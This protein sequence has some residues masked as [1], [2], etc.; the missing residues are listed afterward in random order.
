MPRY[1]VSC[2]IHEAVLPQLKDG[3]P[4]DPLVVMRCFGE[5]RMTSVKTGKTS[6]ACWDESFHWPNFELSSSAWSVGVLEF[7]LQS[8]NAFWR[9]TTLGMCALQLRL[10]CATSDGCY[11]GRLPLTSPNS[12]R[13]I[14]QLFITVNVCDSLRVSGGSALTSISQPSEDT[15]D[16]GSGQL[17][18]LLSPLVYKSSTLEPFSEEY[19]YYHLYINV[20]SL[21]HVE[22]GMFGSSPSITV[23]YG[24]C[25]LQSTKPVRLRSEGSPSSDGQSGLIS[26]MISGIISGNNRPVGSSRSNYEFNQCFLVPIRTSVGKPVLEDNIVVRIWMGVELSTTGSVA[27]LSPRLLAEGVFSLAKLRARRQAPRWFN[28]YRGCVTPSGALDMLSHDAMLPKGNE[29]DHYIGRLLMS[30]SVKRLSKPSDVLVA[31]VQSSYALESRVSNPTRLFVD[32]YCVESSGTFGFEDP[33]EVMIEISC[34]PYETS[35]RWFTPHY[36]TGNP[37]NFDST[38]FEFSRRFRSGWKL[39]LNSVTGRLS[40]IELSSSY[41][42]EEQ[43]LVFV[44]VRCRGMVSG[45]YQERLIASSSYPFAHIAEYTG[46]SQVMPLWLPVSC[47]GS[48]STLNSTENSN[49]DPLE[50]LDTV[51]SMDPGNMLQSVVSMDPTGILGSAAS[52]LA[53]LSTDKDMSLDVSGTKPRDRVA[54]RGS[55]IST[56]DGVTT[57]TLGDMC[58]PGATVN[59]LLT[60]HTHSFHLDLCRSVGNDIRSTSRPQMV[61]MLKQDYELRCYVYCARLNTAPHSGVAVMLSCDGAVARTQVQ[62]NLTCFPVFGECC[63]ISVSAPT[64]TSN[65]MV[66]PLPITVS[67]CYLG[68]GRRLLRMESAVTMYNRLVKSSKI[69]TSS[70]PSPCWLTLS[71]GSQL[72]IY[73]ELVL[74]SEAARV[75]KYQVSPTVTRCNIALGLIGLRQLLVPRNY[76]LDSVFFKISS[77]SYG[78]NL[79][80]E[81]VYSRHHPVGS[82]RW[83]RGGLLNIDMFTVQQCSFHIPL[84][85]LFDPHVEIYFYAMSKGELGPLLGYRSFR[86]YQGYSE[87]TSRSH[88]LRYSLNPRKLVHLLQSLSLK[89]SD[90]LSLDGIEDDYTVPR[91][92]EGAA[93]KLNDYERSRHYKRLMRSMDFERVGMYV[94]PRFVV[95]CDGRASEASADSMDLSCSEALD[96]VLHDIPFMIDDIS[97]RSAVGFRCHGNPVSANSVMK[98]F[99]TIRHS[100]DNLVHRS[101]PESFERVATKSSR[102]QKALR[103]GLSKNLHKLRFCVVSANNLVAEVNSSLFLAVEIGG[104]ESREALSTDGGSIMRL[105]QRTWEQDLFLPED[106]LIN[107]RVVSSFERLDGTLV[108]RVRASAQLDLENRWHSS[109]W[110]RMVR[111]DCVPIERVV[112]RDSDNNVHGSLDVIVQLGPVELFSTLRPFNFTKPVQSLIEL[113]VVVWSTRGVHLPTT[114]VDAR[115]K[116]QL[117]LYVVSTLDCQGY[118]GDAPL[119]QRTDTHYNCDSGS[120]QFN[121]RMVYPEIHSPVGACQLQLSVYDFW[122]VGPPVFIGEATLE[123]RQYVAVVSSTATRVDLSADLPLVNSASA[124]PVGTLKVNVQVLTQSESTCSPVGLGRNS[125]NCKPFLPTPRAGRQWQDWFAHTSLGLDFGFLT[126]Y[127]SSIQ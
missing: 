93:S 100:R 95:A 108:D 23:E 28:F 118:R 45:V 26:D 84:D 11:V 40:P 85:P 71:G 103:K 86:C 80:S 17:P 127:V 63:T 97:P 9:N 107:L 105:I 96:G 56:T 112:L 24:G 123:L 44:R 119:S 10:V 102:M 16:I 25:R 69:D 57:P 89:G 91:N 13:V 15:T 113:R 29:V 114:S 62:R 75:G 83:E 50:I 104:S 27:A 21:E 116:D 122:K 58:D 5:E 55:S 42:P 125:P 77:Q 78:A 74:Q 88:D 33:I 82:A 3:S 2:T 120:A 48:T 98:Y 70:V 117:D 20:Y 94:P 38:S 110:Q 81:Q 72:L 124:K 92:F 126:V 8:A 46:K 79:R 4:V 99:L 53:V 73:T 47:V 60:L 12:V 109:S 54:S 6:V 1:S 32:I 65:R 67:L 41:S 101:Y 106:A 43:W 49:F 66:P 121:W 76:P 37:D 64:L 59:V 14:G 36:R 18:G 30:A 22:V 34:G 19:K 39:N 87:V 61:S 68:R 52:G 90:M 111:K 115:T 7:E 31:H 35:S 51:A